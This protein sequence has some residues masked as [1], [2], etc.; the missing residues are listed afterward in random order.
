MSLP[1]YAAKRDTN[2]GALISLARR[3]GAEFEQAPPLDWWCGWR[4]L[5]VPVE[6]KNLDGRNK[7]TDSQVLFI[8][9]CKQ[10][11]LPVWTWRTEDDVLRDLGA[12][13]TA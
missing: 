11:Q 1:R 9:K 6:V 5:W 2:E 10:R 12:R 4:G 13:R 7:Y 3:I 8:A